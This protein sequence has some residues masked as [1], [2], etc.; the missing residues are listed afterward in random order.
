MLVSLFNA[1]VVSVSEK[2][3]EKFVSEDLVPCC[4]SRSSSILLSKSCDHSKLRAVLDVILPP[5]GS[6]RESRRDSFRSQTASFW[7]KDNS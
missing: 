7:L 1:H 6:F 4:T 2:N 5:G 3:W